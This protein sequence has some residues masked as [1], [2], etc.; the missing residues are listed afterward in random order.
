MVTDQFASLELVDEFVADSLELV[1]FSGT[2]ERDKQQ[3]Y[4][5]DSLE[6]NNCRHEAPQVR[7]A[8]IVTETHCC[9]CNGCQPENIKEI[10]VVLETQT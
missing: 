1:E 4:E 3:R 2:V 5:Q 8:K 6:R 10:D 7:P 9:H